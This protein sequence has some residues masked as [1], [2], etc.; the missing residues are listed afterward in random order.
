MAWRRSGDKPL[1]QAMMV[2]LLT[3]ICVTR[4]Q[5]VV[6]PLGSS[7]FARLRFERQSQH[8]F[9]I[10]RATMIGDSCKRQGPHLLT[11]INFSPGMDK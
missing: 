4:L 9:K 2:S 8:S 1:S 6:T 7:V 10:W 11:W 5:G 3:H